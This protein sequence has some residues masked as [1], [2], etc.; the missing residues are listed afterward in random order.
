MRFRIQIA[1]NSE[2]FNHTDLSTRYA[3]Q[4][5]S[6]LRPNAQRIGQDS[7]WNQYHRF[8]ATR[9]GMAKEGDNRSNGRLFRQIL[10]GF[11]VISG[12]LTP[13]LVF[14]RNEIARAGKRAVIIQQTQVR[15]RSFSRQC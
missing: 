13:T 9:C 12:A 14:S 6:A 4:R 15:S 3:Q 11:P 8:L 10:H 2:K 5:S 1:E 7:G